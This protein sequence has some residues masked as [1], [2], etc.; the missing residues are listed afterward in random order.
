[1]HLLR[2]GGFVS[3]TTTS[4]KSQFTNKGLKD[5]R[6]PILMQAG[7]LSHF[8]LMSTNNSKFKFAGIQLLV[9][10]DK[11]KNL[12]NAKSKIEEAAKNGAN[13]VSLPVL[14]TNLI[15]D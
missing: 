8:R 7:F 14:I 5:F 1:M 15:R 4:T 10:S 9:G 12:D 11:Q 2:F 13:V 6:Y 3:K